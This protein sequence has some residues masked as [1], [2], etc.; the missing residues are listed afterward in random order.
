M[1]DL[2]YFK[3][4]WIQTALTLASVF[5]FCSLGIWQLRRADEKQA[6]L[7]LQQH[8]QQLSPHRLRG[9][10]TLESLGRY[11]RVIARG[12][13]DPD[14][15]ILLDNRSYQGK[16]GYEVLTPLEIGGGRVVLVNRG[17]VPIGAD[18]S[19]LPDVTL[20]RREVEILGR[21]DHFPRMGM[22]LVGMR[23]LTPG[24]PAVV[25]EVDPGI[26]AARLKRKVKDFQIKMDPQ[27]PEGFVREWKLDYLKPERHL[28]YALQWFTF[29]AIAFALWVWFG[30]K[31]A[32]ED[33]Q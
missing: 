32:R 18:R 11:R 6:L 9:N 23:K 20:A 14:H 17:W 22:Y 24:W 29:A 10:E 16:V 2:P 7:D 5:L 25:T 19:T 15:Q 27:S 8:Q 28:G 31:R 1:I 21:V 4:G 3:A 30:V 26:V 12:E 33:D 13:W